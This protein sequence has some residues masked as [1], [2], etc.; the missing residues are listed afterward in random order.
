MSTLHVHIFIQVRIT[1]L[2]STLVSKDK[3]VEGLQRMLDGARLAQVK[4]R[5]STASCFLTP[6][7]YAL[8]W[9]IYLPHSCYHPPLE[10]HCWVHLQ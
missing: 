6:I 10:S 1:Q 9:G 3:E 7:L 5:D 8:P 2:E 4:I